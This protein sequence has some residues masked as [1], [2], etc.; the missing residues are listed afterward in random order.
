MILTYG[1]YDNAVNHSSERIVKH[2]RTIFLEFCSIEIV[3]QLNSMKYLCFFEKLNMTYY[4][5]MVDFR[6]LPLI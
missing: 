2:I 5:N 6:M 4:Y 1:I 3:N